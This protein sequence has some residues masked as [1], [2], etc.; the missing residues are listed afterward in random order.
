[1]PLPRIIGVTGVSVAAVHHLPADCRVVLG[2]LEAHRPVIRPC[3]CSETVGR[4]K[5]KRQETAVARGQETSKKKAGR[6]A[7]IAR[8]SPVLRWWTA[9]DNARLRSGP[10]LGCLSQSVLSSWPSLR[11]PFNDARLL[12]ALR[13]RSCA[14]AQAPRS[15]VSFTVI[16]SVLSSSAGARCGR[17]RPRCESMCSADKQAHWSWRGNLSPKICR[18]AC[19]MGLRAQ[20]CGPR[21]EMLD[22]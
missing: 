12:H 18:P 9:T 22:Y 3:R 10:A 4:G 8:H 20:I 19:K 15:P 13:S 7:P 14:E 2:I 17:G 16:R 6:G 11:T 21:L 5:K 1:L